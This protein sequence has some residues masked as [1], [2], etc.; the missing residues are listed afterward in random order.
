MRSSGGCVTTV[1][2][3]RTQKSLRTSQRARFQE[4]PRRA[5]FIFPVRP[6]RGQL[7]PVS[8]LR[9]LYRLVELEQLLGTG[10]QLLGFGGIGV[11]A[12]ALE[13]QRHA[14][15]RGDGLGVTEFAGSKGTCKRPEAIAWVKDGGSWSRTLETSRP[16]QRRRAL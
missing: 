11:G 15:Q 14:S 13:Q 7:F 10:E 5:S 1:Y 16:R 8:R 12:G 9:A 3:T 2:S 4:A 6:G